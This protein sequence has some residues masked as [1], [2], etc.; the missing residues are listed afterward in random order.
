MKQ[1]N[2]IIQCSL[3]LVVDGG[4]GKGCSTW[5]I[6]QSWQYTKERNFKT[7]NE[8]G[9]TKR[10]ISTSSRHELFCGQAADM[11]SCLLESCCYCCPNVVMVQKKYN[12]T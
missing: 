2:D 5:H 3:L 11:H 12:Q 4:K 6:D 10:R 1:L 9:K 7:C 8:E